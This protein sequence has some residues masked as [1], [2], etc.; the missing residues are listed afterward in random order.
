MKQFKVIIVNIIIV[1]LAVASIVTLYLGSFM[2]IALKLT[3]NNENVEE[4]VELFNTNK[5]SD[6]GEEPSEDNKKIDVSAL[7]KFS[8]E[9]PLSLNIKNE[10]ALTAVFSDR[11]EV[12]TKF[13]DREV[14]SVI[15][16]LLDTAK[17]I[18][19]TVTTAIVNKVV[20]EAKTE[21]EKQISENT[22]STEVLQEE[23]GI[24]EEDI[25]TLKT[26]VSN[27]VNTVLEG[28][29]S[30]DIKKILEDSQTLDDIL[31]A[32]S[33]AKLKT[34]LGVEELNE[35]QKTQAQADASSNKNDFLDG[36]DK[37]VEKFA[38]EEGTINA[39]TIIN[40]VISEAGITSND[41]ES[42]SINSEEELVEYVSTKI[43]TA[44][45]ENKEYIGYALMGMGIFVL[46]VM[47]SWAYVVIK[48]IAKLFSKNKTI[49]FGVPQAFGWMPHVFFV[50]LPMSIIK[51][52]KLLVEKF[53]AQ[54]GEEVTKIVDMATEFVQLKVSSLSWVSAA[55]TVALLI[56]SFFYYKLR[57]QIKK[58]QN[59][60]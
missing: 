22:S 41:G 38:D 26:E 46:I 40:G 15:S 47:A 11:K 18:F 42:E 44:L 58:E 12:V 48:I 50:G 24:S 53:S 17:D 34:E 36:Y 4:V 19:K 5:K 28:G 10:D 49:R 27:A 32:Y 60:K 37:A 25:T 43:N 33:E 16:T 1:L 23:Y 59:I 45:E 56:I 55:C 7:G 20:E 2:K 8:L 51:L 57:K 14:S 21:I 31:L 13:I 3:V 6:G 30:D 9:L 39:S 54:L 35:E 52:A 29:N